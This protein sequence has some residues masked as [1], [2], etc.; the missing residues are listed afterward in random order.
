MWWKYIRLLL[1]FFVVMLMIDCLWICCRFVRLFD[2]IGFLNYV[3]LVLVFCVVLRVCR[4]C[5]VV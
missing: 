5:F 4:V 2:E 1:Y 3:M